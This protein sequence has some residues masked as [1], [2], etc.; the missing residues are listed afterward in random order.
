M[1]LTVKEMNLF[2]APED[3][4]LIHACNTQGVWGSGIAAQL[5]KAYPDAFM[6]YSKWCLLAKMMG[7]PDLLAGTAAVAMDKGGRNVGCLFTSV[8]YGNAVSPPAII[9]KNTEAALRDLFDN[10]YS[11]K[12]SFK[13]PLKEIYSNTI[14]SGFFKTPWE[15]T[16][17][18]LRKVLEDYPD[19]NWT[20]CVYDPAKEE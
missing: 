5:K 17:V 9:L 15:D 19:I 20:V 1:P 3:A 2:D 13:V 6:Q 4:L 10:A 16:E 7:N 14:N 11:L 12:T 8:G 18:V